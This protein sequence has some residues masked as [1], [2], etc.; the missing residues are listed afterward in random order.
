MVRIKRRSSPENYKR[1]RTHIYE[2][3]NLEAGCN[4]NMNS[5]EALKDARVANLQDD[6]QLP[7][8]SSTIARYIANRRHETSGHL[9]WISR[10]GEPSRHRRGL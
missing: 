8:Q 6:A 9:R 3:A 1:V 4:N 7:L 2:G 5:V 10:L